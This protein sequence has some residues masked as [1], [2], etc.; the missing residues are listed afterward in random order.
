MSATSAEV[1]LDGSFGAT[2]VH[3][4]SGDI[5][6]GTIERGEVTPTLKVKRKVVSATFAERIERLYAE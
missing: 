6:V 3:T 2:K 1:R 4:V 5:T